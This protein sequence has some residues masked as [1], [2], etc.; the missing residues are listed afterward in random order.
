MS[1]IYKDSGEFK[2]EK[3]VP[4]EVPQPPVWGKI[5]REEGVD[6]NTTQPPSPSKPGMN[7]AELASLDS[8]FS[9]PDPLED[10]SKSSLKDEQEAPVDLEALAEEY[11]NKGVQAGIERVQDDYSSSIKTL[12]SVCVELNAIRETILHNSAEEIRNLVLKISEKIIRHSLSSQQQT[13][14]KTV[15]EALQ[16]AVRSDEFVVTVH[17]DDLETISSRSAEFIS[18]VDGL[19][20]II[21]KAD[22][23]V[24]QGGCRIESSNC[25]VDATIAGQLQ[26]ISDV[27]TE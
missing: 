8:D 23:K 7:P 22:P 27:L 6:T 1:K 15:D 18:S 24:E 26:I 13:I 14:V 17:P 9:S 11:F 10:L 25:T 21:I 12:Q 4:G 16:K 2:P 19:E 5:A 3:I 20:K